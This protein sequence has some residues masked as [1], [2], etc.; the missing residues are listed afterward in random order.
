MA[1]EIQTSYDNTA[2]KFVWDDEAHNMPVF[3]LGTG[4][5]LPDNAPLPTSATQRDK[6]P[7]A[8]LFSMP[9][10]NAVS[11]AFKDAVEDLDPGVHQFWPI[12]L[13]RKDG[14]PYEDRY[15]ILNIAQ[16]FPA[17]IM[18]EPDKEDWRV[19]EGGERNGEPHVLRLSGTGRVSLPATRGR[20]LWLS[21]ITSCVP[22]YC[23]DAM[24]A[25][26][27]STMTGLKIDNQYEKHEYLIKFLNARHIP[28]TDDPWIAEEQARPWLDWAKSHPE[29][30]A[31]LLKEIL[32]A[33]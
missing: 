3:G 11:Q 14:T 18:D 20:H 13:K 8:D 24:M 27:R 4:E 25:R 17:I 31:R 22:Y 9:G 28:E 10:L 30:A 19:Y 15:Y 1:Y 7:L 32:G 21:E 23:T 29:K 12:N 2:P 33:P 6:E 26:L 5:R 16:S